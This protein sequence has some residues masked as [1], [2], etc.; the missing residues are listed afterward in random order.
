MRKRNNE[1]RARL[2]NIYAKH[3]GKKIADIEALM[4]RDTF[5]APEDAI[6]MGLVDKVV[7]SRDDIK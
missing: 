6:K 3:S 1:F 7:K 2:N 4:D 5:I